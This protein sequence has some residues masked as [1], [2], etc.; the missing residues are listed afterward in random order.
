M[1]LLSVPIE[2]YEEAVCV[3]SDKI[4]L[5]QVGRD[6]LTSSRFIHEICRQNR[7]EMIPDETAV[8]T[9]RRGESR[10]S[11]GPASPQSSNLCLS[12]LQLAP[13]D[14]CTCT[15]TR[16]PLL[17]FE[18]ESSADAGIPLLNCQQKVILTVFGVV[19][20]R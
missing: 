4:L 1:N 13:E 19:S 17:N 11:T 2:V 18:Q 15:S 9:L 12:T 5:C 20:Y 3:G 10:S 16:G 8:H 6:R 7:G 14:Q